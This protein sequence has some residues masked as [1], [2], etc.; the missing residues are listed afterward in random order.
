MGPTPHLLDCLSLWLV[1]DLFVCCD[2]LCKWMLYI[3]GILSSPPLSN[4]FLF[5]D[6]QCVLPTSHLQPALPFPLLSDLSGWLIDYPSWL[7]GYLFPPPDSSSASWFIYTGYFRSFE[8]ILHCLHYN[9]HI[10]H[11]EW[12][13]KTLQKST[14]CA[15]WPYETLHTPWS[16]ADH[17]TQLIEQQI[18]QNLLLLRTQEY[19]VYFKVSCVL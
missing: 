14:F 1:E 7:S 13:G 2:S 11:P 8:E 9:A 19:P 5:R 6:A 17:Q 15:F 3:T 12:K 16:Q 4:W 18:L 10:A